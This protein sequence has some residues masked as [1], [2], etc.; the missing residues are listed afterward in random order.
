MHSFATTPDHVV[1]TECPLRVNPLR[2]ALSGRPFIENYVWEPEAGARFHVVDRATGRLR[3]S[4]ETDPFFCFHHVNAFER[5]GGHELV[6]DLVAYDDPAVIEA[7]YLDG[8]GPRAELPHSELRRYVIDLRSGAVRWDVLADDVELPRI[9]Y[10]RSN[11]H[12]YRFAYFTGSDGGWID[13]LVKVDVTEASSVTWS[14]P[15]CYP[16]EPVFVR[17]PDGTTED[18][19]VVLSVVLDTHAGRS[20]LL[21]LDAGRFEELARAEAPHHI[22]FG[23]HGIHVQGASSV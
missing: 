6:V 14:A 20:F 22:P 5:A 21:V 10:G 1:L 23:F 7:L 16:G 4:Y 3:G 19:G 8:D 9:D 17:N 18:D 12:D 11:G 2:L 15:G 13:R